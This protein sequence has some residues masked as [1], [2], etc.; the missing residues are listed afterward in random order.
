[1]TTVVVNLLCILCSRI[2]TYRELLMIFFH[3]KHWYRSEPLFAVEEEDEDEEEEDE[4]EAAKD[5]GED[6]KES[7]D[8]KRQ[9]GDTSKVPRPSSRTSSQGTVTSAPTSS[10]TKKT[11]YEFLLF[12]YLLRFVHREGQIGDFARAGLLFLMDVAMSPGEPTHRLTGEDS[13]STTAVASSDPIGDAA[14]SLAEYIVDGDFSE[15]LGAGLGAVY[16][17]LPSK[18]EIRPSV[19]VDGAEGNSMV[20]GNNPIETAERAAA[21]AA[22]EKTRGLVMEESTSPDFKSRLDHFL[23]LAEF[24]EDVLR[25]NIVHDNPDATTEAPS[26]VG[27]AIVTSISTLR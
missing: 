13:S 12:N 5:E 24:L 16:S 14:L 25:R 23:K 17:Q 3:D 8:E 27:S 4:E 19:S 6:D 7:T 9:Q 11:E 18:L 20:L 10:L 1:M 15:V 2:R 22:R 21:D 26:P